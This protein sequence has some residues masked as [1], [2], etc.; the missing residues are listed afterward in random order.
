M[1]R[2]RN[3]YTKV[4]RPVVIISREAEWEGWG[5]GFEGAML[6]GKTIKIGIAFFL[7][8]RD[9]YDIAVRTK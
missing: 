2:K 7:T 6:A 1:G 4:K 9:I 5:V 3:C 8:A